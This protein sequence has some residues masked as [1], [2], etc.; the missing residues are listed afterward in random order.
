MHPEV[1]SR[2]S[3]FSSLTDIFVQLGITA[4]PFSTGRK[5]SRALRLANIIWIEPEHDHERAVA[6]F[7]IAN[8]I[9][10]ELSRP[11]TISGPPYSQ[12]VH[13]ATPSSPQPFAPQ[14]T[15]TSQFPAYA[16]ALTTTKAPPR[17]APNLQQTLQRLSFDDTT[18]EQRGTSAV[19]PPIPPSILSY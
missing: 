3:V 10:P 12:S 19:P 8:R 6:Q 18:T 15:T 14:L 11:L 2:N 13:N 9:T 4:P 17:S 7:I 16:P 1:T 5:K